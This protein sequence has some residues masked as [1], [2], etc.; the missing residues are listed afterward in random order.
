[1]A[2]GKPYYEENWFEP[3]FVIGC[4]FIGFLLFTEMMP[5]VDVNSHTIQT[6]AMAK[7]F[8]DGRWREAISRF[9]LAP[10]YPLLIAGLIKLR[11]TSDFSRLMSLIQH[12]NLFFY[13]AS[14][15]LVHYFVRRQIHKPYTFAITALYM[16]APSTLNMAWGLNPEMTYMVLSMGTLIAIDISL[17]KE[18][19]MGG[20]LSRNEIILC[21]ALLGLSIMTMAIGYT[22]LLGFFF[23]CLKRFGLKKSA[24]VIGI[25]MLCISPFVGRDLFY[26]IRR[27]QPYVGNS[28]AIL[29]RAGHR[30]FLSTLEGYADSAV[31]TI[32]HHTVGNLN[33]NSLDAVAQTPSSTEPSNIDIGQKVWVRWLLAFIAI[34]GAVYGFQQYTGIGTLYL[35][36]YT[37]VALVLMPQYNLPLGE[38]L[39]LLLFYL[40]YGVTRT[41]QWMKKMHISSSKFLAPVLTVWI[42]LCSFS[43]HLAQ[44]RGDVY[45]GS[46]RTPRVMYMSTAQDPGNRLEEAQT[47]TAHRKAMDWL[48]QHTPKD[49][50]IGMPQEDVTKLGKSKNE[51]DQAQ[52]DHELGQYDY[53]V[54]ESGSAFTPLRSRSLP[55]GLKLVYEDV[56]GHIRIWRVKPK[57]H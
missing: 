28:A 49:A 52:W 8:A 4:M 40:Y 19:A 29:H 27:P 43:A 36:T 38:V 56:P 33:L 22:L 9:N 1:M 14:A 3:A 31:F 39:P 32:A 15:G 23:V 18:S 5:T 30:G 12:M 11:H 55:E 46:S 26:A 42:L 24:N 51:E 7:L 53:L 25:I 47:K 41:G 21:G 54:E 57:G 44:A 34:T 50:R 17:S 48:D 10:V 37:V 45:R 35:S 16:L 2:S 13:M 20:Q 6:V